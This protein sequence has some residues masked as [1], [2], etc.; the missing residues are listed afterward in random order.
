MVGSFL[1][2]CIVRLP[3]GESLVSL[4]S[5]C[6]G[7]KRPVRFYDNVPLLSYIFLL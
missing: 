7:C 1:N 6:P 2:V 4:P 5:H 3:K